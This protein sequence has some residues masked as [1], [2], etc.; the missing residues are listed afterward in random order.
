MI[1]VD[2]LIYGAAFG[3]ILMLLSV[4]YSLVYGVGGIINLA[5]GSFYMLT[6]YIVFWLFESGVGYSTA[7]ILGIVLIAVVGALSY[8]IFIKHF[9]DHEVG[10]MIVTFAIGYL[11][12]HVILI[13]EG[14]SAG[15]IEDRYLDRL[16]TGRTDIL[17][18]EINNQYILI[19]IVAAI[20]MF[21]L[22]MFIKYSKFGKSIRAVSQDREAAQLMGINANGILMFTIVLSAVLA[23]IAAI[24]YV[25][26]EGLLPSYGWNYL[27]TAMS[28]VILGGLGSLSGS[29]I[30]AFVISYARYFTFYYI[31]LPYSLSYSGVIHLVV[32]VAMLIFRPQGIMGK[33]K[34]T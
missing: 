19:M 20:V 1:I 28:V 25:P 7:I 18:T 17:G 13:I 32:I 22:I 10:C 30:G 23:G 34:R 29:V 16:V 9:Q 4:G 21:S 26:E 14:A 6:G 33:K 3:A 31:D 5:H 2:V 11:I 12:E 27:L 8:L 15:K 24:L